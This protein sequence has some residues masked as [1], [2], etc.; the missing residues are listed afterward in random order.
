MRGEI[1]KIMEVLE[2][3]QWDDSARKVAY[4]I[5]YALKAVKAAAAKPSTMP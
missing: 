1:R 5:L 4:R 3:A 2:N